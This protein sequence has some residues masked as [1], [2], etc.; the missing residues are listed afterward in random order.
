MKYK[1]KEDADLLQT[2]TLTDEEV[3]KTLKDKFN[4]V[5]ENKLIPVNVR[6]LPPNLVDTI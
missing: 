3:E 5:L 1:Y 2:T 4:I 6:G